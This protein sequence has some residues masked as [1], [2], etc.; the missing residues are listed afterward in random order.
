MSL[1]RVIPIR[2]RIRFVLLVM[3][4]SLLLATWIEGIRGMPWAMLAI[5]VIVIGSA[6]SLWLQVQ[7]TRPLEKLRDEALRVASGESQ[8]TTHMNRVDEIGMTLRAVG[9]LGLMFRWLIDDV[10]EQVLNVQKA[11]KEISDGNE[12]L[13]MRTERAASNVQETASS[14][15][16]MAA[17]VKSNSET[18]RHANQL[19]VAAREA[20]SQ[21]NKAVSEVVATMGDINESSH[22]I[23]DIIGLIDS[24]AFQT[25]ILA[26]NAAVEAARAGEHGRGFAVV[27]EEVRSL[28][29]RSA[30]AA[31]EI[32]ALIGLSA[33]RIESGSLMVTDAGKATA[34]IMAK[35]QHVSDLIAEIS[36]ATAEQSSGITQIDKAVNDLDEITQANAALVEQSTASSR[37]L[38][39]QAHLLVEAVSVFR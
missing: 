36:A 13:S 28:A 4:A 3:A 11:I 16:E 38:E 20:A 7:I 34:E 18:A 12:N 35:V 25:N 33:E 22:K 19:S 15:T 30:S 24:I 1:L 27:S 10:S 26:L 8:S 6:M 17:T 5:S 39:H 29:S 31:K 37:G 23:V 32:K 2:W 14:V 9:Q 21:G